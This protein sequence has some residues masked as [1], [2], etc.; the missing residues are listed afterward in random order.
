MKYSAD[1]RREFTE[2]RAKG[3]TYP[4]ISKEL[5]ISAKTAQSWNKALAEE[6]AVARADYT[7][8]ILQE[9]ISVKR[10]RLNSLHSVIKAIDAAISE[11]DFTRIPPEKLL[12]M[13]LEYEA[14]INREYIGAIGG[15]TTRDKAYTD[16]TKAETELATAKVKKISSEAN[17]EQ[18][19]QDAI[20]AMRKYSKHSDEPTIKRIIGDKK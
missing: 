6:I 13:K 11:T 10:E 18:L 17:Q 19:Y 1:I 8:E 9:Y 12:K 16:R 3:Y 14:A 5:G 7:E 4:Q 2:L 20:D 15:E